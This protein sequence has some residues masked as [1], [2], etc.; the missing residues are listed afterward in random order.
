MFQY[1]T[2]KCIKVLCFKSP[3]QPLEGYKK[4]SRGKNTF[5]FLAVGGVWN[6]QHNDNKGDYFC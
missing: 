5:L 6:S 3:F 4:S 1:K 2:N